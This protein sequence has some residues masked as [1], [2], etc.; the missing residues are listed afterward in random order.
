MFEFIRNHQLNIMLLLCGVSG[1]MALL[2]FLTRFLPKR[3]KMALIFMELA[4]MFLLGFDRLSY[5]YSGDISHTGYMMTR[6]SNFFVFFLTPAVVFGFNLY[7]SDWLTREGGME[8]P[9]K[10]L[11]LVH[12]ASILSMLMAVVA[13]LTGL[14]YTFDANNIYHRSSGFLISYIIPVVCP[15]IQFAVIQKN[16]KVFSKLIYTSMVL[17]IF[18]PIACGILQVFAY[19]ISIVNIAMVLVSISLY[20]FTYL[21]VNNEVVRVHE[22]ELQAAQEERQSMKKLFDQMAT[23]FVSAI[24][25][26]D[27]FGR[28]HSSR[29]AQYARRIA[30]LS[31]KDDGACDDVY[32]AALLHDVGMIGIPDRVIEKSDR[33]TEEEYEIMKK[34]PLIGSEILSGIREYPYL[35]QG[36]RF[37]CERYDGTGYPDGLAGEE[38]PDIARIVAVAEAYDSMTTKKRFRDP[39]P[40]PLVREVFVEESGMHFDPDYSAI[41]VQMIDS[42]NKD[43]LLEDLAAVEKEIRC[44]EY[45]EQ[46]SG[47]IE[48]TQ[49]VIR[50][51]FNCVPTPEASEGFA[52]PAIIL[53]DSFDRRVH[54]SEKAIEAYDYLEY[55]EVWFDEHY[56]VT[57]ARKMKILDPKKKDPEAAG[58]E[59]IPEAGYCITAA[60]YEDHL[61]LKMSSPSREQEVIVALPGGSKAAYIGLTGEHCHLSNIHIEQ[62][63]ET[64]ETGDIPRIADEISYIDRLESDI[65]NVQIDRTRS[66]STEGVEIRDG[67]RI[68]FHTMTLPGANFVWHCPYI[69][70]FCSDDGR[71]GGDHYREYALIKLNGE[72]EST[73]EFAQNRFVMKREE[74]FP[75][76]DAWKDA[77]K[78]GMECE[79]VFERKAD[80]VIT[81][82]ENLGIRIT[83]TTL[84]PEVKG[85]VYAALTGDRCALTDIR[86]R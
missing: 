37:S 66:A 23:S 83:N 22:L 57:E 41:M 21:D 67:M 32:Y 33:L 39:M 19:G 70:L 75:G 30:R 48:I 81:I 35:S 12:L 56:I 16:R 45:R 51:L 74:H 40:A 49:H 8:T 27:P 62:T 24:D 43:H 2:L 79:V 14:Y 34:K 65:R 20:I 46:V 86:I 76:W 58:M 26:R 60:R 25:A 15:L 38:I 47:G 6:I 63:E 85:K 80:K 52:G 61:K 53:F 29:V 3:R 1:T 78:R 10:P 7:L 71:V 9:P 13:A 5:I 64:V 73:E 77:N 54:D 50:I 18:V 31:G 44:E 42:D 28:G 17:Y 36:A 59:E 4:A 84:I 55:G 69:V 68:N 11:K 72:N 82:T